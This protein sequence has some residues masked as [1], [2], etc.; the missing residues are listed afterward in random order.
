MIFKFKNI[1]AIRDYGDKVSILNIE[2]SIE[3]SIDLTLGLKNELWGDLT[4]SKIISEELESNFFDH[5]GNFNYQFKAVNKT[6]VYV[7]LEEGYI[8]S[9][10]N[11]LDS[12]IRCLVLLNDPIN[13]NS[14]RIIYAFFL[15]T[16]QLINLVGLRRMDKVIR[17]RIKTNPFDL[18]LRIMLIEQLKMNWKSSYKDTDLITAQEF[19]DFLRM[20]LRTFQNKLSKGE[21]L[22][23]K[24][25]GGSNR[26]KFK[27][28]RNWIDSI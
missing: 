7:E 1:I 9:D 25:I 6:A 15:E 4:G 11:Q 2:K 26:W 16:D 5:N 17:G 18:S 12:N 24:S 8:L 20:P 21:I 19:A 3:Q 23:A 22:P 28:I 13:I 27:D 10:L 14:G